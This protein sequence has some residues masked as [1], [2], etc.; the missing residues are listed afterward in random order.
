MAFTRWS[1]RRS[2]R[3]LRRGLNRFEVRLRSNCPGI[4]FTA[5]I[6]A[7]VITEPPYPGTDEEIVVSVRTTLRQAAADVSE[8]CDPTDLDTARDVCR[9]HLGRLRFLP[10][11]PPVEFQAKLTLDLSPADRAAMEALLAAQRRQT[12]TDVL[13]RQKTEALAAELADPA[14]V[15]VRWMEQ[16]GTDWTKPPNA[17]TV[18]EIAEAF[19]RYHTDRERTIEHEALEVLRDFLS[20]FP[21]PAQKRMLYTLLAAGMHGAQRPQHAAKAEALLN[22]STPHAPESSS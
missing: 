5:R 16:E 10:T 17:D 18:T 2:R 6:R 11:D 20:S 19:G 3:A 14:A 12:V 8:T 1:R 22:G 4:G 7:T 13:R 21:D 9:Q 15:M